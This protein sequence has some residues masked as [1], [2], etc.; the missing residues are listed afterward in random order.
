MQVFLKLPN[1]EEPVGFALPAPGA[2]FT[3]LALKQYLLDLDGVGWAPRAQPHQIGATGGTENLLIANAEGLIM[4]NNR[5]LLKYGV[6]SG[7]LLTVSVISEKKRRS[8]AAAAAAAASD[9]ANAWTAAAEGHPA[10]ESKHGS[11]GG[12]TGGGLGE[13]VGGTR[14]GD[15][16]TGASRSGTP[17]TRTD[18]STSSTPSTSAAAAAETAK[19]Q[20]TTLGAVL[21]VVL[22]CLLVFL[23]HRCPPNHLCYAP[24]VDSATGKK[25][26]PF[27]EH[28]GGYDD[29]V[30]N[31][32][33]Y[34][35]TSE[36]ARGLSSMQELSVL[37]TRFFGRIMVIDKE[38]MVTERD[39]P[40]YHEMI[41]HVP[42]AY[43]AQEPELDVLVI[44]GGDGG[45]LQQVLRHSNVKR[46][47]QVEIDG[48]VINASKAYFPALATGFDDPRA[49]V[50]IADAAKWVADRA[51]SLESMESS[52]GGDS[53]GGTG[54]EEVDGDRD[55]TRGNGGEGTDAGTGAGSGAGAGA[56]RGDANA[57]SWAMQFDVILV[58]STDYGLAVPLFTVEFYTHLRRLLRQDGILTFNVDS[59]SWAPHN[60]QAASERIRDIFPHAHFYQIF[61]PTYTSGHYTFCFASDT[62]HPYNTPVDWDAA[63]RTLKGSTPPSRYYTPNVHM[64][65]FA[66]PAFVD[67]MTHGSLDGTQLEARRTS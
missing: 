9:D 61:Q 49:T 32:L 62:V 54:G 11:R 56:R 29:V 15:E 65:A 20:R 47:T 58:D 35:V 19:S 27:S 25:I 5:T 10:G 4:K 1:A 51:A 26:P 30:R 55:G 60:V 6:Q 24:H 38:I 50:I 41:A 8:R 13:R 37:E 23:L 3:T 39:E 64:A 28:N 21:V 43:R 34:E 31:S 46:A 59:P 44:G 36:L 45:T 17:G 48:A 53:G 16:G 57:S 42:L 12:G 67:E 14:I 2:N 52:G 18:T 22:A 40:H 66:L 63:R 7:D 33:V